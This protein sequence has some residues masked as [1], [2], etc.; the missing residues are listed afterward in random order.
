MRL[1]PLV[2]YGLP[3]TGDL[4]VAII[5]GIMDIGDPTLAF[6]EGSIMDVGM[7]DQAITVVD[8]KADISITIL[9]LP[10]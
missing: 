10:V 2:F 7:A 3:D 6:T 4:K 1:P 5:I 8:G 9:L